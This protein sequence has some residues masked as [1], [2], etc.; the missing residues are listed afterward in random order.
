M[1]I[2]DLTIIVDLTGTALQGATSVGAGAEKRCRVV[3]DPSVE[4][5]KP[6]VTIV[7][8]PL[9]LDVILRAAAG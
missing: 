3:S 1:A 9:D 2:I 6:P 4:H 8:K 7:E 5:E